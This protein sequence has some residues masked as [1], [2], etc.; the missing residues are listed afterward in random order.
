[1]D[2]KHPTSYHDPALASNVVTRVEKKCEKNNFKNDVTVSLRLFVVCIGRLGNKEC[3][4][5]EYACHAVKN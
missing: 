5:D 1:M 2:V 3:S 4:M